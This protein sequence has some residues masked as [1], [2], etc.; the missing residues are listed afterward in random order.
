MGLEEIYEKIK[1]KPEDEL[2]TIYYGDRTDYPE[3]LINAIEMVLKERGISVD[4][5]EE[6]KSQTSGYIRGSLWA[7]TAVI[8]LLIILMLFTNPGRE[9]YVSYTQ[10]QMIQ[11]S[12]DNPISKGMAA[13]VPESIID[14][15]SIYRDYHLFGI[16]E[17]NILGDVKVLGV[18]N[19]CILLGD[20][21][22][23]LQSSSP[24]DP[25]GEITADEDTGEPDVYFINREAA[26]GH[27]GY[28]VY[29]NSR[30]G[31]YIYYPQEL[32]PNRMPANGDG[33]AFT[34]NDT[35][36]SLTVFGSNLVSEEEIKDLYV[37]WMDTIQGDITYTVLEDNYFVI[38][39]LEGDTI[40]YQKT[41]AGSASQNTFIFSY[42]DDHDEDYQEAVEI[43]EASFTH[44]DL[45][46]AH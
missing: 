23:L 4:K 5:Q 46:Q 33:Q 40:Y 41:F 26:P 25:G 32:N 24:A 15:G 28:C 13:I 12:E 44:G 29:S 34:S 18:F 36:I 19:Q 39:W 1:D 35:L 3:E 43:M 17:N 38:S 6:K 45:D 14:S 10:Q 30:Y 7:S 8:P 9:E 27:E 22:R 21:G 11:A 20:R 42:P 2:I 31:F 16:Y 37:D